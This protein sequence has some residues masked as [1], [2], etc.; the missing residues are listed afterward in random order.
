VYLCIYAGLIIGPALLSLSGK[1]IALYYLQRKG[2]TYE[3]N[4]FQPYL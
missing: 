2:E 4:V 3:A 1:K